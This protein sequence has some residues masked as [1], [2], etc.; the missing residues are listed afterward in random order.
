[1]IKKIT[2]MAALCLALSTQAKSQDLVCGA[3]GFNGTGI[4]RTVR[5]KIVN[6]GATVAKPL[7]V[8]V[9]LHSNRPDGNP[10]AQLS[11]SEDQLDQ[12]GVKIIDIRLTDFK[13]FRP[14]FRLL[15]ATKI[16]VICDPKKE[17]KET[18]ENN[19]TTSKILN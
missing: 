6:Q 9:E 3:I 7:R 11:F 12:F 5:I 4:N 19:N 15:D 1:M 16:V 8:Y 14:G 18:N 10:I 13:N 2:G 17:V